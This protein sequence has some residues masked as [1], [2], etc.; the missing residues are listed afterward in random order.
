MAFATA[1]N[2]DVVMGSAPAFGGPTQNLVV[3]YYVNTGSVPVTISSSQV[4]EEPGIAVA[5]ASDTCGGVLPAQA[6]CRTVTISPILTD[7][8][9]WCRMTVSAKGN[10]R[11]RAEY[12]NSSGG[13]V[14]TEDIR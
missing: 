9:F 8:A 12:R 10:L 1:A 13:I 7:R 3:C 6:R 11:G 4:L 14:T 2:A 5:E